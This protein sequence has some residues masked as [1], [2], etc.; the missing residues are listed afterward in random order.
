MWKN[1]WKQIKFIKVCQTKTKL[2]KAV[3][4]GKYSKSFYC[5]KI[6]IIWLQI[7]WKQTFIQ[8]G[9]SRFIKVASP[10]LTF[11]LF[12]IIFSWIFPA[13]INI[14][15]INMNTKRRLQTS[16]RSKG[17]S[18]DKTYAICT[19]KWRKENIM[20]L[21]DSV[22]KMVLLTTSFIRTGILKLSQLRILKTIHTHKV[23]Q[24]KLI[25]R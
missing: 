3:M 23:L 1:C 24:I 22:L 21:Q 6:S 17:Q 18:K 12:Q 16:N 8:N 7:N 14:K 25:F 2:N 5:I 19:L 11:K 10:Y 20:G 4:Y 13:L 9:I 15:W